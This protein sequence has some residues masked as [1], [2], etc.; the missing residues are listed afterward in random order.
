M[1]L[2]DLVIELETITAICAGTLPGGEA[3]F[4]GLDVQVLPHAGKPLVDEAKPLNELG[5]EPPERP[6]ALAH[7]APHQVTDAPTAAF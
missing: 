7:C 3:L 4:P 5:A 6:F 1:A 2:P